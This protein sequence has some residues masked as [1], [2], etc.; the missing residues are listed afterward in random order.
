MFDLNQQSAGCPHG[1]ARIPFNISTH[2]AM[3]TNAKMTNSEEGGR[4][5]STTPLTNGLIAAPS[6]PKD[7]AEKYAP[8]GKIREELEKQKH[9]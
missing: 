9:H 1:L 6:Q 7:W 5:V 2:A 4:L 8:E 3:I